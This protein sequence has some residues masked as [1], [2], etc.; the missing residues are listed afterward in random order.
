MT[1]QVMCG[2][3]SVASGNQTTVHFGLGPADRL[4]ALEVVWPTGVRQRLTGV[5][6]DRILTVEEARH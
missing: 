4:V 6:V 1:R 2:S 3:T 5:A